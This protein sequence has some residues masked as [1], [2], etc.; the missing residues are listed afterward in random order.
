MT[1][2]RKPILLCLPI[3]FGLAII[4]ARSYAQ[5]WTLHAPSDFEE[6]SENA[7]RTANS[8][9]S[10][11]ALVSEC[12]AKF[13]GRRKPGGGY[14]YYD[15]MQDRHFDI[16]GPNPTPEELR[17]IDEQYT[18][19][20]DHQ[21]QS[22]IAAAFTEQQKQQ[23]QQVQ[24]DIAREKRPAPS[25]VPIPV[26]RPRV[27][28]KTVSCHDHSISCGWSQFAEKIEDFKRAFIGDSKKPAAEALNR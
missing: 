17:Q 9:E 4:P 15:F 22:I 27:R 13:A 3:V 2:I 14:T 1:D 21:R 7:K 26:S 12:D 20:L 28:S 25:R 16:A 8:K 6:C 5:W 24:A 19:Y 23:T 10:R 11:A 18:V